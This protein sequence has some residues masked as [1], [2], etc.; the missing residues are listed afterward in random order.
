LKLKKFLTQI[1]IRINNKRLKLTTPFDK[2][3]YAGMHL[4]E[5]PLKWFQSYLSKT[6]TNRITTTNKEVRYIFSSWEDFKAQLV[7]MYGDFK[8]EETVTRKLY[9]LK[10]T[11]SA[12][13]YMT[14]F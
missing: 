3:I 4:I 2:V 1:K 5:K 10:Q 7:Q 13:V 14:E 11:E 8:K 6:Q 9:E 12:I